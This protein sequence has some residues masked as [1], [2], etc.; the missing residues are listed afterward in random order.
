M[1]LDSIIWDVT[2]CSLV[3]R[4]TVL[5]DSAAFIFS[6][7][8]EKEI[9]EQWIQAI[10]WCFPL[11]FS[12]NTTNS[13]STVFRLIMNDLQLED[14]MYRK[15]HIWAS[16]CVFPAKLMLGVLMYLTLSNNTPWNYLQHIFKSWYQYENKC[17][18]FVASI[19]E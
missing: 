2:V 6:V 16:S 5:L 3:S 14:V 15:N 9:Q 8:F 11:N 19:C 13:R 17:C 1:D 7:Q 18:N 4:R 10:C 12:Q